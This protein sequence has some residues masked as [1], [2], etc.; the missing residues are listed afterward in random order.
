MIADSKNRAIEMKEYF[1]VRGYPDKLVNNVLGK[2]S[3]ACSTLL[4]S[5]PAIHNES[6]SNKARLV[7]TYSTPEPDGSCSTISTSCPPIPRQAGISPILR[8]YHIGVSENLVIFSCTPL[9][10][11]RLPLVP[12]RQSRCQKCKHI[13]DQTKA[14]K[15]HTTSVTTSPVSLRMLCIAFLA[16]AS[17]SSIS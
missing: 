13:T 17:V 7:L 15:A 8:W 10:P 4:T 11:R 5:T 14:R 9:M 12:V 16:G 1:L 2:V 3:T 6:T